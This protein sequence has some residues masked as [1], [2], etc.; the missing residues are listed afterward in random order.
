M[1]REGEGDLGIRE[2]KS[3]NLAL[4]CKWLWRRVSGEKSLWVSIV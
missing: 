3:F 4:L 1:S 2:I